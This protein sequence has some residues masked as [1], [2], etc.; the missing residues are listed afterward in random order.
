MFHGQDLSVL[1][2]VPVS[3]IMKEEFNFVRAD[4]SLGEIVSMIQRSDTRDYPVLDADGVIQGMVWFHD[5][6]E[7][8]LENNMYPLLIA[9]DI[10]GEIP[11]T[12]HVDS[13]LADALL[14]FSEVDAE[15]L[16][17]VLKNDETRIAGVIT[18]NELM[19]FYERV[20]LIRERTEAMAASLE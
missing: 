1:E 5:V 19:R 15:S 7:V 16:P 18:R 14:C 8:M 13:S 17:V 3:R 11:K 4:T 6:R 9:G 20:L 2:R 10:Q 12:V